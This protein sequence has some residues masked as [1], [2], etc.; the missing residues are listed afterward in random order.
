[1]LPDGGYQSPAE[2]W[3][4]IHDRMVDAM[5]RLDQAMRGRVAK[6]VL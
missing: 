6:L 3:P 5:I 4:Q 1:V 2:Q